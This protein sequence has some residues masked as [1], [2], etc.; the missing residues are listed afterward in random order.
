MKRFT[1]IAGVVLQSVVLGILLALAILAMWLSSG[2]PSN[3]R[4][5]WL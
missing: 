5:E 3:F 4:Y 1:W 2:T